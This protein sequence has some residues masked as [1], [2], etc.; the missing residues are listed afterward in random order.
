MSEYQEYRLER[1]QIDFLLE[2]G[3]RIT[4]VS[5]SLS[6]AFLDFELIEGTKQEW[7]QLNIKT[8]EGRKYFSTLLFKKI[9]LK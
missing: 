5:E 9:E 7:K 2:R 8:P 6:G 1:E 3:Y 4:R